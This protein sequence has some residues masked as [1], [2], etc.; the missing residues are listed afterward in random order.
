MTENAA[1]N[2]A[3]S[4]AAGTAVTGTRTVTHA[5]MRQTDET[6][7]AADRDL[8]AAAWMAGDMRKTEGPGPKTGT[9]RGTGRGTE[10]GVTGQGQVSI[11]TAPGESGW[12]SRRSK[13]ESSSSSLKTACSGRRVLVAAAEVAW[14]TEAAVTGRSSSS[15]SGQ[16]SMVASSA[17]VMTVTVGP[18]SSAGESQVGWQHCLLAVLKCIE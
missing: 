1:E 3:K 10:S 8:A 18:A 16:G 17:R 2:A 14:R 5:A 11:T 9:G 12:M 15:S 4:A 6:G 13:A 7:T